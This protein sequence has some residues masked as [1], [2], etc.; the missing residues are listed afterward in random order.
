MGFD[1]LVFAERRD[2]AFK[3]SAFECLSLARALT[4][5]DGRVGAILVGSDVESAEAE[6]IARG[7]D[8]GLI[9]NEPSLASYNSALYLGEIEAA[10]EKF[11][12]AALLFPATAMGKELAPAIAARAGVPWISEAIE[13]SRDGEGLSA[14]KSMYGGRVFATVRTKGAFLRVVSI[15]PGAYPPAEEDLA[16]KGTT[17]P[18]PLVS[19]PTGDRARVVEV[20][21]SAGQSVDLQEAEIVVSGGRGLKGPENFH[22][23]SELAGALGGAVGASR[24]VVDA[25]WIDHQ[26][27]VGQTGLTVAPKLYI[28]CG[29]SGAIQHLAGMRTSGCIVAINKDPDAP[30]F[31]VADYGI[32]GDLFEIV[33][34]L[35]E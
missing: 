31:K 26:H 20:L 16:H 19:E 9:A 17:V 4:G 32:V 1:V 14:R 35:T 21:R 11:T 18:L 22:L 30:I 29:I 10:C 25:G 3:K 5:G 34:V 12:A 13:V 6:L 7:A 15:R 2:G 23:I 28:A 33:P 27:Q 24:A 8:V